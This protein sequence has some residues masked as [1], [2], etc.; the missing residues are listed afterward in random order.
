M[1]VALRSGHHCAMPLMEVLGLD[2]T[3]RASFSF[4]NTPQ[5]VDIFVSALR[6]ALDSFR[7]HEAVTAAAAAATTAPF[8]APPTTAALPSGAALA[9]PALPSAVPAPLPMPE[10]TPL[11]APTP[12]MPAATAPLAAP[13]PLEVPKRFNTSIE[14]LYQEVGTSQRMEE[15]RWGEEED[16]D[17]GECGLVTHE[18]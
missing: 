13:A 17:E 18:V 2:A 16:N 9:P 15:G 12:A 1:G 10:P 3:T 8:T 6:A 7:R 4:Y 11:L 5:E 14:D